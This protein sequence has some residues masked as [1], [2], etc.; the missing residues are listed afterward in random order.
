[1]PNAVS[2]EKYVLINAVRE[3][4]NRLFNVPLSTGR[5]SLFKTF[6][7]L[8]ISDP[9]GKIE[10]PFWM[11]GCARVALMI[12]IKKGKRHNSVNMV[13]IVYE[14]MRLTFNTSIA[15]CSLLLATIIL[16]LALFELIT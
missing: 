6:F 4:M 15:C 1:M 3:E 11:S 16:L 7:R 9:P 8:P 13:S 2:A 14:R 5:F 12:N 10:K